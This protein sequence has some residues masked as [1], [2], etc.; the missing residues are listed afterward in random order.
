M[1][2]VLA[3]VRLRVAPGATLALPRRSVAIVSGGGVRDKIERRLSSTAG[4]E[5]RA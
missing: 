2:S 5:H 3:R 4:K 1:K